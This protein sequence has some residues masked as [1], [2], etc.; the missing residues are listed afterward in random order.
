MKKI[1]AVIR[2]AITGLFLVTGFTL[3]NAQSANETNINASFFTGGT[4]TVS[5]MSLPAEMKCGVAKVSFE[6]GTRTIWHS[7]AG[8]QIIVVTSGMAWYQEKGKQKQIL[9]A[10]ES[11]VAAPGAMHWHGAS[12]DGPMSHTVTTPNLDMGGV[13]AGIAVTDAEYKGSAGK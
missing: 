7:H 9:R 6:A 2:V 13:T 3:V 8:G 11:I 4:A 5:R 1:I 12:P 10:G